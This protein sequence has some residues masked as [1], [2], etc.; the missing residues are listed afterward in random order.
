MS[1][2]VVIIGAGVSGLTVARNLA[3]SGL[4]VQVLERQVN[5][6]GNAVSRRFGGFLM[7]QGPTTLNAAMPGANTQLAA[8]DLLASAQPLGPEVRKRYLRDR[9][10]LHGISVNPLGFFLSGYLS[11]LERLSMAAEFMRPR[12]ADNEEE[13]IHQF[14]SRR[15]GAGFA[16]KVLEPLAAGIFMGDSKTLSMNGAF[17]K[18]TEMEQRFGSI[19][20]GV[21]AAKR[22]AEPG[23]QMLSWAEGMAT[24]PQSLANYPG[25]HIQTGTTV[26]RISKAAT[27]FAI[28]TAAHGTL[29]SR[30]VV[31][32][33]QPHVASALLENLDPL[34]AQATA[35]II[36]PPVAVVFLGYR[37]SQVGHPLDGLGF[38]STKTDNQI[39]SGAQFCSTMFPGRAP[40]DHVAISCYVGGA[41][42]P[43][44]AGLPEQALVDAVHR[45][46]SEVLGISGQP[47]L[48]KTHSWPRGL[49][50]YTL[51]HADR[52]KI[53]KQAAARV[54]G[55]YLTGNFID[56]VSMA[57][58]M[59]SAQTVAGHLQRSLSN[60]PPYL[61]S[62][63]M[64][65]LGAVRQM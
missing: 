12:K 4:D 5:I 31:L 10:G 65:Q 58:C 38:L 18:L 44:I 16:D 46:V 53:I 20:R 40:D 35:E 27:G 19:I 7:E 43:E 2:D 48:T 52:C 34:G 32:A 28:E 11:P 17:P 15:F 64:E 8:L 9:R 25:R 45:E 49:P 29:Q 61:S 21:L 41:R 3:A 57:N 54:P 24:I 63:E 22:G 36:A 26:T 23:R 1:R 47:V 13:T 30:T 39:I 50:H 14:A 62:D 59:A 56:G 6:G 51:G 37:R 60:E 33:V 55:L 42:N